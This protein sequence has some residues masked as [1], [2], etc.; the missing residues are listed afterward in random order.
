MDTFIAPI[1]IT[2][3]EERRSLVSTLPDDMPFSPYLRA[4]IWLS[5]I[6]VAQTIVSEWCSRL[7]PQLDAKDTNIT[8]FLLSF[9]SPS[10]YSIVKN[11]HDFHARGFFG[12]RPVSRSEDGTS[13]QVEFFWLHQDLTY[14]LN[15][16][17][18]AEPSLSHPDQTRSRNP[19]GPKDSLLV[20]RRDFRHLASGDIITMQT[21]DPVRLPLPDLDLL[22]MQWRLQRIVAASCA[23]WPSVPLP[24]VSAHPAAGGAPLSSN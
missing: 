10:V 4:L 22:D 24:P 17:Y 12:L 16:D 11:A 6:P 21:S 7:N 5:D 8:L 18:A 23:G 2:S 1:E 13:L 19:I 14:A 15:K 20:D 9:W 3:K